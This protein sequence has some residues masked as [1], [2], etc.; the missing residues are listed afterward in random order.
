MFHDGRMFDSKSELSMYE[1]LKLRVKAEDISELECQVSVYL[2]DA[3]ILYRPD[4]KWLE[5]GEPVW[6]EMKGIETPT[7][8]IK[9]RLWKAGYGPG[10]LEV[11]KMNRRG[12]FLFET[13]IPSVV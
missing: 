1:M 11:W 8:R 9:R 6:G 13:L 2:T 12:P 3:R 10:K 5:D 7:W 4:F